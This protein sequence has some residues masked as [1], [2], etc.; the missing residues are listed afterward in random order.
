MASSYNIVASPL[1]GPSGGTLLKISFGAPAQ[2]DQ[3]VKDAAA[4]LEGAALAGGELVLLNGPA[5]LPAACVIAH[6]VAHRFKA[7]GVFDPKMGGYVVAISHDENRP[8]GTFIPA[9]EVKEA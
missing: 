2:N 5:S 6:A 3:I 8:L 9:T 4:A 1:A 7:V